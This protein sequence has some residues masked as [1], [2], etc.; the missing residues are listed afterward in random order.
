MRLQPKLILLSCLSLGSAATT[1]IPIDS[2]RELF[3]HA[4]SVVD[5]ARASTGGPWSFGALMTRMSGDVPAARFAEDWMRTWLS[6]QSVGTQSLFNQA[7]ADV[8]SA[9]LSNWHQVSAGTDL[10][11]NQAPFRLLAIVNRPDL[12]QSQPAITQAAELRFVYGGFNPLI[13]DAPPFFV[14]F[15]FGVPA[16]SCADVVSWQSRWHALAQHALG[17]P[18]YNAALQVLTDEITMPNPAS[19]KPNGSLIN[20]L[21]SNDIL[22]P[23]P[24]WDLREWHLV[25]PS[26]NPNGSLLENVTVVQTP[27]R[28]LLSNAAGRDKLGRYLDANRAAILNGNHAVPPLFEGAPFLGSHSVNDQ[29]HP[30]PPNFPQFQIGGTLWWAT[31]YDGINMTVEDADVRHNF[32]LN[33]CSGCHFHETGISFSQVTNRF[34]GSP[35]TLSTFLTGSLTPVPDPISPLALDNGQLV[36]VERHFND[37]RRRAAIMKRV[38]QIN[39]AAP[40]TSMSTLQEIEASMGNRP[41]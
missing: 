4:T 41:H 14:I 7:K 34:P 38:L 32:A 10:D 12:L 26:S 30:Q 2:D 33:T 8:I 31:G 5:D 1:Q 9:F 40:S 39:C 28:G 22:S 35:T 11:L 20:Q 16:S 24:F 15:E 25:P 21:R 37:L 3:V 36:P 18:A 13:G 29:S 23:S 19:G 17:S 6:P 27:R